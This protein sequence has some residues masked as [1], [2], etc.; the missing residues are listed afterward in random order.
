MQTANRTKREALAF[1]AVDA[2]AVIDGDGD[3]GR[4]TLTLADGAALVGAAI[5]ETFAGVPF[6][7]TVAERA[8]AAPLAEL[9]AALPP[10]RALVVRDGVARLA[11]DVDRSAMAGAVLVAERFGDR[12]AFCRIG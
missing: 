8:E 5:V 1:L 6:V 7:L 4:L 10:R 12:S 3:G 2:S 11:L 9:S